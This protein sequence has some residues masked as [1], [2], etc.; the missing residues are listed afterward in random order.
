[1]WDSVASWFGAEPS[2]SV[3]AG[4]N[5]VRRRRRR[6]AAALRSPLAS[7]SPSAPFPPPLRSQSIESGLAALQEGVQELGEQLVTVGQLAADL[8]FGDDEEEEGGGGPEAAGRAR[9]AAE[10]D[11]RGVV[12]ASTAA[13]K[14]AAKRRPG[15]A[16]PP[17]GRRRARTEEED[18][19]VDVT[20][21][22]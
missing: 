16:A 11:R 18:E 5:W 2:G 17:G 13:D 1:M 19:P 15:S 22:N 7:V 20:K 10:M 9:A 4:D 8:L 21:E 12:A 14:G 6:P 3:G